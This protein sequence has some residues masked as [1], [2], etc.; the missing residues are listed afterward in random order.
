MPEERSTK[1]FPS[2][3]HA[4]I[5]HH[6]QFE[7]EASH[8]WA[9]QHMSNSSPPWMQTQWLLSTLPSLLATQ[10]Q[11]LVSSTALQ[12]GHQEL[13]LATTPVEGTPCLQYKPEGASISTRKQAKE[14]SCLHS[15]WSSM[16]HIFYDWQLKST[17]VPR[18]TAVLLPGHGQAAGDGGSFTAAKTLWLL[19]ERL[20]SQEIKRHSLLRRALTGVHHTVYFSISTPSSHIHSLVC[21]NFPFQNLSPQTSSGFK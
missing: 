21:F 6:T 14:D 4:L 10:A 12:A 1:L 2:V 8:R 16:C 13:G 15:C 7:C 19:K 9:K 20:G 18:Q 11:T 17:P 3:P 5:H